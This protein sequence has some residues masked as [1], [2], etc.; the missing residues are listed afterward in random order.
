M[1]EDTMRHC[2]GRLYDGSACNNLL[3]DCD[4]CCTTG[5]CGDGCDHQR[6][7]ADSCDCGTVL[8]I[9]TREVAA[10]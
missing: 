7:V 9:T 5:C 2:D 8:S 3:F 1:T 4:D 6:F 10:V